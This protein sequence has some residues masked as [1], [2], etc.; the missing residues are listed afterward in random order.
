MFCL[1]MMRRDSSLTNRVFQTKF[2]LGVCILE[3][4]RSLVWAATVV[5]PRVK[6]LTEVHD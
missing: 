4:H 3:R 1:A 2:F 5:F 6:L